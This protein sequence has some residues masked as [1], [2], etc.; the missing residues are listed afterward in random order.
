MHLEYGYGHVVPYLTWGQQCVATKQSMLL[1]V[2]Y[3]CCNQKSK[4]C[5]VHPYASFP[6][7]RADSRFAPSQWETALLCNDISHWLGASL[8]SAL[9]SHC[10][11]WDRVGSGNDFLPDGTKPL[12]D[13]FILTYCQR[14]SFC[15]LF[16]F[17][18][19]SPSSNIKCSRKKSLN[20][21][22]K[23]LNYILHPFHA[24]ENVLNS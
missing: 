9:L 1:A 23:S 2:S 19:C 16:I 24:P 20:H 8:E 11:V 4:R 14:D 22:T 15:C 13:T 6:C 7:C 10:L 17:T 21:V 5:T 3:T 12:P 18:R